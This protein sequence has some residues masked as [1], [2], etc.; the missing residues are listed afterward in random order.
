MNIKYIDILY[1]GI[2]RINLILRNKIKYNS[3]DYTIIT[4]SNMTQFTKM[5]IITA[6]F[7]L[8]S[9]NAVSVDNINENKVLLKNVETLTFSN[10]LVTTGR[11]SSPVSQ[12]TCASGPCHLRPSTVSCKNI[13]ISDK[14]PSWDCKAEL[15]GSKLSYVEVSCEGYDYPDDPY[16]LVGSCG[17]IYKLQ[18]KDS[19]HQT[20]NYTEYSDSDKPEGSL[21]GLLAV[22]VMICGI[23]SLCTP[24]DTHSRYDDRPGFW[25]GVGAAVIG[26]SLCGG[27]SGGSS[28][29]WGS[30]SYSSSAFGGTS[31][32]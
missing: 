24:E 9:V 17:L 3:I 5:I 27:S 26:A 4:K 32:R 7:L 10:D 11:R 14:D 18:Y 20:I 22:V 28:S 6:A 15:S 12:M 31:R 23:M 30:S 29:S 21:F 2:S 16:I 8:I 19:S 1:R 25:S 13:G